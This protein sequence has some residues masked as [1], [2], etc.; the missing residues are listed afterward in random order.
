M[1]LFKKIVHANAMKRKSNAAVSVTTHP[2]RNST[3]CEGL[4]EAY[5]N[6]EPFYGHTSMFYEHAHIVPFA[7]GSQVST[8][9][10]DRHHHSKEL[11]PLS[12]VVKKI[13]DLRDAAH[14]NEERVEDV[15]D[16]RNGLLLP[17]YAHK[18]YDESKAVGILRVRES[19][20]VCMPLLR[21]WLMVPS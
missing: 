6:L 8:M 20:S 2:S 5:H 11:S 18:L 21:L 4:D 3:F 16:I 17:T 1:D 14:E 15:D 12:Q 13:F 19:F 7:T 10:S 9:P